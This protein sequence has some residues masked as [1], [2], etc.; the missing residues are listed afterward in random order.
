MSAVT[1]D[2][3]TTCPA[4]SQA[5]RRVNLLGP[6]YVSYDSA[7]LEAIGTTIEGIADRTRRALNG[8][9]EE[10]RRRLGAF[11]AAEID[12]LTT[13]VGL[14]DLIRIE[15]DRPYWNVSLGQTSFPPGA[16]AKVA[17]QRD[18]GY[19]HSFYL[20]SLVYEDRTGFV[21]RFDVSKVEHEYPAWPEGIPADTAPLTA[22]YDLHETLVGEYVP[23]CSCASCQIVL[24]ES[25]D[26]A[27][28]LLAARGA[29]GETGWFI[30][31]DGKSYLGK[32][33]R[34]MRHLI[35]DSSSRHGGDRHPDYVPPKEIDPFSLT[36][37]VLEDD[38]QTTVALL[39]EQ[40]EAMRKVHE[41][42]TAHYKQDVEVV[43]GGGLNEE[44]L[45]R[46]W[47]TEY[48]EASSKINENMV[49]PF[50]LPTLKRPTAY[51][52]IVT[53]CIT[54]RF[55]LEW[56]FVTATLPEEPTE[57][58]IPSLWA[59]DRGL[60]NDETPT[61]GNLSEWMDTNA[62][63]SSNRDERPVVEGLQYTITVY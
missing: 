21:R 57:E 30:N 39:Q 50:R 35:V 13:S 22:L 17:T 11:L 61:E 4:R 42:Q 49:G 40:N 59:R 52:V 15:G 62:G 8:A 19:A 43:I 55:R 26:A 63:M 47:C 44:A 20:T 27:A 36:I 1:T 54:K 9:P 41:K 51:R 58:E 14:G 10:R 60:R 28:T 32:V 5:D 6:D 3:V 16:V 34:Y 18:G 25:L 31:G 24:P 53:K 29:W 38:L 56:S 37:P 45:T 46:R 7:I 48:E 12:L 23:G 2:N 33:L